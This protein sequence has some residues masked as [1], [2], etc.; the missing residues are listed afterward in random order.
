MVLCHLSQLLGFAFNLFHNFTKVTN[1]PESQGKKHTSDPA[2]TTDHGWPLT[3]PKLNWESET[4]ANVKLGFCN[5]KGVCPCLPSIGQ[6]MRNLA[7]SDGSK[8]EF[9]L[10]KYKAK[11]RRT[12]YSARS[13]IWP[14][15]NNFL[16]FQIQR[17]RGIWPLGCHLIL[18][19]TTILQLPPTL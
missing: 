1:P 17:E 2:L 9:S 15:N 8:I 10:L 16:R 3:R 6:H 12:N 7:W 14:L 18:W 11:T 4:P 19:V 5:L 13:Y